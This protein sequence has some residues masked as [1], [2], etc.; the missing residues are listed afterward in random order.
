MISVAEESN[1]LD[2][3]L[4][5]IAD[6]ME[7]QTARRLE[8]MVKLIEPLMLLIMGVIVLIIVIALLMPIMTAGS[9]F[10]G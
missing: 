9:V 2:S 3:V 5:S 7:K 10:Q 6:N 4:I 1:T 8:L